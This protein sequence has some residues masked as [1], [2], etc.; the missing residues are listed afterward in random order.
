[1]EKEG[2][3]YII[4]GVEDFRGEREGEVIFKAI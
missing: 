3:R 2:E 4:M 1:V